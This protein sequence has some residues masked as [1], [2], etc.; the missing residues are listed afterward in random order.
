M[1]NVIQWIDELQI[2]TNFVISYK[3]MQYIHM[4]ITFIYKDKRVHT[5]YAANSHDIFDCRL[6]NFQ[7]V[8]RNDQYIIN[9]RKEVMDQENRINK[10][11]INYFK[12]SNHMLYIGL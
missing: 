3:P 8:F 1:I 6:S 9:F 11:I 2:K 5:R 4:S 10:A 7:H 12:N